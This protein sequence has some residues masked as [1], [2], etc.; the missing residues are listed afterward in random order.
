VLA[1]NAGGFWNTRHATAD[2]LEHTFA[3]NH[4]AP[5]LLTSLL[6]DQL[7]HSA[8]ARVITVSSNVQ[9]IGRIDFDD[10]EGERSYSGAPGEERAGAVARPD[11]YVD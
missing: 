11:P 3:L 6:L 2:G 10:L 1:N 7:K 9:A 4:L 5:F 8:P